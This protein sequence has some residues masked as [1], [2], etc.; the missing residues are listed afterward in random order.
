MTYKQIQVSLPVEIV[1]ELKKYAGMRMFNNL[2]EYL[3]DI[4]RMQIGFER[5]SCKENS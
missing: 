1:E 2:Q 5:D 3:R 4:I